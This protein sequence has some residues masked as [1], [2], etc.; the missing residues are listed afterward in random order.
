MYDDY[1]TKLQTMKLPKISATGKGKLFK[2]SY[3]DQKYPQPVIVWPTGPREIY[4]KIE[5]KS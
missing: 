5:P 4:V 2:I 1:D 3:T